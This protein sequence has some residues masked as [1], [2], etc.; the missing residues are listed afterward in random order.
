[1]EFLDDGAATADFDGRIV[2]VGDEDWSED[3][4]GVDAV[5][6]FEGFF[7]DLLAGQRQG[8]ELVVV[9]LLSLVVFSAQS[10]D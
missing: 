8:V 9:A 2:G 10:L 1:M 5:A 4:Q 3:M 7:V 6:D